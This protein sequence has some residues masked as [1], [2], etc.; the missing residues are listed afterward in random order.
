MEWLTLE[1]IKAVGEILILWFVFYKTLVFFEGTRAFQVL[2][3]FAYLLIFYLLSEYLGL[4]RINWLLT[5]FFGIS[6]I[7]LLIIFHQ[8]LRQGLARLG[9][10]HLFSVTPGETEL[11]AMIDEISDAVKKF[12]KKKTGCLI[13]IERQTKLKTY[14]ESGI[15]LDARISSVILQSVFMPTS[16]IHDGGVI[17]QGDRI[18]AVSCL[19]PLTENPN[20]SKIIG[21]RHRAAVGLTE[22]TDA[23][24]VMVSEE[25]GAMSLALD[26][27]FIA[28]ENTERL[29][30]LLHDL[31]V[32]R[33]KSR[34]GS[35]SVKTSTKVSV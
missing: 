29:S 10:Q 12:I 33:R 30:E 20:F 16:P 34:K 18:A 1:V 11:V 28:V 31:M 7:A 21:T 5:K 27:R 35:A 32:G 6:I 15:V 26:G 4:D 13:A 2:R 3:G 24:V 9:Q 17:L 22:H 19:F 25:T 8:E 23:V 14:M